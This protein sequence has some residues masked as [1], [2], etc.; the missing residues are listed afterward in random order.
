MRPLTIS[1]SRR[2]I[3]RLQAAEAAAR[4]VQRIGDIDTVAEIAADLI[5][6]S[7]MVGQTL[8]SPFRSEVVLASLTKK[9]RMSATAACIPDKTPEAIRAYLLA[10]ASPSGNC[11]VLTWI[12]NDMLRD[13][14][15]EHAKALSARQPELYE[16]F[17]QPTLFN[18]VRI[19]KRPGIGR[20]RLARLL[21]DHA[22]F[23]LVSDAHD[24]IARI[25]QIATSPYGHHFSGF[26]DW[27]SAGHVLLAT[28][29]EPARAVEEVYCQ[30]FIFNGADEAARNKLV[31]KTA[32]ADSPYGTFVFKAA[33]AARAIL[34]ARNASSAW[35]EATLVSTSGPLKNVAQIGAHD[36]AN[37][38]LART[39]MSSVWFGLEPSELA[40]YVAIELL[41][42]LDA[43]DAL[44]EAALDNKKAA[45]RAKTPSDTKAAFAATLLRADG[46]S[47][48]ECMQIGRTR[49]GDGGISPYN[50]GSRQP[51]LS[52]KT[53]L[54][55]PDVAAAARTFCI[56]AGQLF[57]R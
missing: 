26:N 38:G 9:R 40:T 49:G 54:A 18:A 56:D 27:K 51:L 33:L 25:R 43:V 53:K 7:G 41:K 1:Y 15:D 12:V 16:A 36:A 52:L 47:D 35:V 10:Q 3:T 39:S 2:T 48:R 13:R 55:N 17:F 8:S 4:N 46:Q 30:A 32:L 45:P 21:A 44:V 23:V 14:L 22:R 24:Q 34:E 19:G 5:C 20:E 57:R 11:E 50:K 31:S 28:V 37:A 6:H 42:A 29:A